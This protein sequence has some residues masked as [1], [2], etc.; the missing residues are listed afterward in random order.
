MKTPFTIAFLLL[1]LAGKACES[2]L[3]R[4]G[5]NQRSFY[6]PAALCPYCEGSSF[7]SAGFSAN[8]QAN[9]SNFYTAFGDDGQN[10]LHGPWDMSWSKGYSEESTVTAYSMRYAWN[11]EI[12][13]WHLAAGFRAGWY[14]IMHQTGMPIE[15]SNQRKRISTYDFDGGLMLTNLK[16]FYAGFSVQNIRNQNRVMN[17]ENGNLIQLTIPRNFS[18]MAGSTVP[19]ISYFDLM[20]ELNAMYTQNQFVFQPGISL[21]FN[22]AFLI[23]GGMFLAQN[24]APQFD[25]RTGYTSSAF[26]LIGSVAFSSNGIFY[27]TGIVCR[28]NR[29]SAICIGGGGPTDTKRKKMKIKK[30]RSNEFIPHE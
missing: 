22:H 4:L 29:K 3:Y 11:Q 12:G 21:R 14:S 2:H 28:F 30:G 18:L 24:Q 15:N 5:L 17:T 6:N 27:E 26:K 20:P 8:P 13:N 1:I 9:W 25:I 7:V 23:G 19:L 10:R 16:G